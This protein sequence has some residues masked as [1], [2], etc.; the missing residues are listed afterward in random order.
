MLTDTDLHA[1]DK[2]ITKR[3]EPLVRGQSILEKGQANFEKGQAK[4]QKD[5]K[6][7]EKKLD[8]SVNFLDKEYL[9]LRKK[10]DYYHPEI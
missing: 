3:I 10:V 6:R 8:I 4:I 2:L 9:K 7:I 5:L 1:I